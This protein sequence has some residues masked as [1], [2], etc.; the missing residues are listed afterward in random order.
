MMPARSLQDN[1]TDTMQVHVRRIEHSLSL[2]EALWR[3]RA[4]MQDRGLRFVTASAATRI[5]QDTILAP[6]FIA[7]PLGPDVE[8]GADAMIGALAT[9]DEPKQRGLADQLRVKLVM[10]VEPAA[11]DDEWH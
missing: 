2:S 4:G 3:M 10:D 8:V 11:K 7:V 6:A 1:S 9:L 5:D